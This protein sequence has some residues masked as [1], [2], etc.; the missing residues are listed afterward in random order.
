MRSS[1]EDVAHQVHVV[2]GQA[3][4]E[5]RKRADEVVCRAGVDN[6]VNDALV[7][8]K[9]GLPLVGRDM[10]ELVDDVGVRYGHGLAHLRAGVGA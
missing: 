1:V 3:L 2:H 6:R 8:S 7:V 10:Q 5:R 9:A 4:D